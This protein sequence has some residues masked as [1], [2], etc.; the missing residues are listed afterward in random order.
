MKEKQKVK[1]NDLFTSTIKWNKVIWASTNKQNNKHIAAVQHYRKRIEKELETICRDI[2]T[3]LEKQLTSN[4]HTESVIFFL[5]M[6]GDY[7]R[8]LSEF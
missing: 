5:K 6:K 8:Y 7:N 3:M 1:I 2:L 4:K